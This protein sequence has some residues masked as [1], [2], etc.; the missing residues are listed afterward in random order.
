MSIDPP[1]PP[2]AIEDT[3]TEDDST[4][5]ANTSIASKY[6]YRLVSNIFFVE[7]SILYVALAVVG[8]GYEIEV[9]GIPDDVL[10]VDDDVSW[11]PY[12]GPG[13]YEDDYIF[14]V[15]QAWVSTYQ[16]LYF[17]AAFCFVVTGILDYVSMPG[18][19]GIIFTLAGFFGVA[20]AMCVEK[21]DYISSVLNSVSVHLFMLEAFNLAIYSEKLYGC[22]NFYQMFGHFCFVGGTVIDVIISYY[23]IWELYEVPHAKVEIFAATLW[24]VCSI[25]T[26]SVTLYLGRDEE[27]E[28]GEGS[29][30][31]LESHTKE[32]EEVE[33]KS[34]N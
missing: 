33:K 13:G 18:C 12:M 25:V 31:N 10:W 26:L 17:C 11:A 20:S 6:G 5:N 2:S 19:S 3:L 16:I 8:T 22:L 7:A 4:T 15:G 1:A 23:A 34:G 9:Q 29:R 28:Q 14:L 30:K 32:E 24:L 21:L 27:E